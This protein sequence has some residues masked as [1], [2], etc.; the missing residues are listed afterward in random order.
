LCEIWS[1]FSSA[2]NDCYCSGNA[3]FIFHPESGGSSCLPPHPK[4]SIPHYFV[5]LPYQFVFQH[6]HFCFT[7]RVRNKALIWWQTGQ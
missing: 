6:L 1:T 3:A 7:P 5:Y 2:Y 4:D